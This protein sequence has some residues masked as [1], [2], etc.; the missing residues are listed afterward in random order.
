MRNDLHGL[1]DETA[2][3]IAADSDPLTFYEFQLA[4]QRARNGDG[5]VP[6]NGYNLDKLHVLWVL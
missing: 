5:E 6:A 1:D 4:R 3:S 2:L